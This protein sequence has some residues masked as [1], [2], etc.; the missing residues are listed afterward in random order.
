M[1]RRLTPFLILALA[2]ALLSL[3][4]L[5]LT[6]RIASAQEGCRTFK[7]T[8]KA[9]CG[10]FLRYWEQHGGLMQQGYPLSGEMGEV[11]SADG[12]V[13]T[14]QY[15]ERAVLE[16]HPELQPPDVLLSLLGD[17]VYDD[18]YPGG[19]PGQV[20]STASGSVLF[21][22]T[23]HRVGG[24]FLNYWRSHGGLAQQGYPISN[25]FTEQSDLDGKPYLVQYFERAVF[26]YHPEL[27]PAYNVLLAQLGT[28]RYRQRYPATNP[29]ATSPPIPTTPPFPPASVTPTETPLQAPTYTYTPSPTPVPPTP[30]E[31]DSPRPTKTTGATPCPAFGGL[32][33][34]CADSHNFYAVMH[35]EVSG[36]GG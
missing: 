7:E 10:R 28:L 17:F 22:Q 33:M 20:A 24:R 19:A 32:S 8:D 6:P 25:E 30:P 12:K 23:G 21:P 9:A 18:R 5:S 13:Y 26:E 27:Q 3:P 4:P 2:S 34:T 16:Y 15:F 36:G 14:V 29:N 35:W 31:P 11:S 1:P